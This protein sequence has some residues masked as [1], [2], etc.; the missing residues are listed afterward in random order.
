MRWRQ[1]SKQNWYKHG[2]RNTQ[3]FHA[4]ANYRRKTNTIRS[5]TD[6]AGRV[7]KKNEDFS[8]LFIDYFQSLFSSS[9]PS[10]ISNCLQYL[11]SRVSFE[12]NQRLLQPFVE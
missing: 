9:N 12:M 10:N 5:I 2:D 11:D 1:R 3:F 7:W 6:G 8:K 4:W